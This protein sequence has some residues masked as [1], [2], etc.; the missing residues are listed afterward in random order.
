MRYDAI[1]AN[2]IEATGHDT[3][4]VQGEQNKQNPQLAAADV[5]RAVLLVPQQERA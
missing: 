3:P 5:D 1:S 4:G 2:A